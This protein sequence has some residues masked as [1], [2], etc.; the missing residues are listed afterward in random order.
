MN[1]LTNLRQLTIY[2]VEQ[3]S[4][5]RD[6]LRYLA[7]LNPSQ[8]ALK[9]HKLMPAATSI[10]YITCD[11]VNYL[12]KMRSDTTHFSQLPISKY[13]NFSENGR[14]DPLLIAPSLQSRGVAAGSGI[15]AIKRGKQR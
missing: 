6:Q 11:N 13:F 2:T 5:W 15:A 12:V 4:L 7:L 14:G 3:V 1:L 10:P 9:K 8:K